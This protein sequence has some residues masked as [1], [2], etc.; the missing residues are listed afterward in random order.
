MKRNLVALTIGALAI[1]GVL[2]ITYAQDETGS[3]TAAVLQETKTVTQVRFD[4]VP[5]GDIQIAVYGRYVLK[6][7]NSGVVVGTRPFAVDL[8]WSNA[9]VAAPNLAASLSK[10]RLMAYTNLNNTPQ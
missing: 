10:L 4:V 7:T 5:G 8:A 6:N 3:A 2:L 9:V 1:A